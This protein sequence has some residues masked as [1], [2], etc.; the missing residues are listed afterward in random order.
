M[1]HGVGWTPAAVGRAN[2]ECG[3]P[4]R[5]TV[6]Q[7]RD[8]V[9]VQTGQ[10]VLMVPLTYTYCA[11]LLTT[12][13]KQHLLVLDTRSKSER[14]CSCLKPVRREIVQ[15]LRDNI[16]TASDDSKP[17]GV[18]QGSEKRGALTQYRNQGQAELIILCNCAAFAPSIFKG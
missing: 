9:Q 5:K 3:Q 1:I 6:Q 16:S 4:L 11:D 13:S 12:I 18:S 15:S 10:G 7:L 17:I 2:G 8:R 14:D